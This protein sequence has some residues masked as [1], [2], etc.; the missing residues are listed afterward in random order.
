MFCSSKGLKKDLIFSLGIGEIHDFSASGDKITGM[1]F[2]VLWISSMSGFAVVVRMEKLGFN[3]RVMG[4]IQIA[5][6]PA[7]AKGPGE[8]S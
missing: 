4:S 8:A 1:R 2:L 3:S 5:Y 6:R 7:S